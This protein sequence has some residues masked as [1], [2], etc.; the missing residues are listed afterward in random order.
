[1]DDGPLLLTCSLA[2]LAMVHY[3]DK[4]GHPIEKWANKYPKFYFSMVLATPLIFAV[5]N[6]VY[7]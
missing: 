6:G 5:I 4:K 7:R 3:G 2:M 1:M